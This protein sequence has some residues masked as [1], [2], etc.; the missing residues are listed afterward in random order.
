MWRSPSG[1]AEGRNLDHA[2]DKAAQLGHWR[3]PS[4]AAEDRNV[5]L[6]EHLGTTTEWRSPSG[7]AEDRNAWVR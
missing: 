1:A 5:P 4:G 2:G 3:S 6:A 7:A